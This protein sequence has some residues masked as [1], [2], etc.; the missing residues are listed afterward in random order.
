MT[1]LEDWEHLYACN[2]KYCNTAVIIHEDAHQAGGF[3]CGQC[4][5]ELDHVQHGSE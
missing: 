3:R 5:S 1:D 2:G 4:G